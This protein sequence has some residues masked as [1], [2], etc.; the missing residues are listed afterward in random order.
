[1]LQDEG[2]ILLHDKALKLL[3]VGSWLWEQYEEAFAKSLASEGVIVEKF[4]TSSFFNGFLGKY[5][6]LLPIP[7]L[8][9]FILNK[10][11]IRFVEKKQFDAVLFWRPTHI[12]PSTI[13]HLNKK[14]IKTISYNNDDPFG[15][16]FHNLAPW[17]HIFLWYWYFKSLPFFQKNFFYRRINC[18]EAK[19]IGINHT[20][21]LMPSFLPWRDKPI[22]LNKSDKAKFLCDVVFIGHYEK[23]GRESYIR[24]L[25]H[26]SIDFKLWGG[27]YWTQE[28]LGDAYELLAPIEPVHGQDY[29][30]AI[31]GSKICLCFLSKLNRDQYTRRCFEIPATGKVLL[32]ERTDELSSL[33]VENEEAVFF[34]T[35]EEMIEKVE[36]LLNNP[37]ICHDIGQAGMKKSWD[38]GYDIFSRTKGFLEAIK[39]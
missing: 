20:E 10:S 8:K 34:S 14:N 39:S 32:S 23:D 31:N 18:K 33:F 25:A 36:W 3:I 12:F 2:K 16:R 1:L 5:I 17:H 7:T 6:Q 38:S 21:L 19:L 28:V 35:K 37:E 15:P 30:K 22:S 27:K 24:A 29:V 4:S 13:L 26:S 9:V 11:I